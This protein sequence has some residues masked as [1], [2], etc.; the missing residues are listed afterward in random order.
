MLQE[1]VQL[2]VA[3]RVDGGFKEG[4]EDILQHLL[5]VGQLPLGSVHIAVGEGGREGGLKSWFRA[6][7]LGTV[8]SSA[9]QGPDQGQTLLSHKLLPLWSLQLTPIC[10][11]LVAG[12][13]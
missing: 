5:E 10:T 8:V 12:Y 2:W 3:G 13:S 1:E 11:Q 7:H 4:Q 6:G 9:P